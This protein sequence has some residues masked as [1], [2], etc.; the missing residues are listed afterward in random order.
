MKNCFNCKIPKNENE[1]SKNIQIMTWKGNMNKH[2]ADRVSG[3]NRKQSDA[4]EVYDLNGNYVTEYH[5]LSE[6]S[7]KTGAH[8]SKH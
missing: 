6:A 1:F 2:N 5:S 8:L 4:V 7:R 3:K